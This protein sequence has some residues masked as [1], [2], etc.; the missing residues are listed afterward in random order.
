M[1]TPSGH[2]PAE[3]DAKSRLEQAAP[4]LLAALKRI[5]MSAEECLCSHDDE[6]CCN[7]VGVF[8]TRCIAAAAIAKAERGAS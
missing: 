7:L 1:S 5:A 6:N 3:W 4:E 2:T 8:C